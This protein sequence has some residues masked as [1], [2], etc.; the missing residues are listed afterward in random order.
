MGWLR[1]DEIKV[2]CES[3][4]ILFS[5]QKNTC[6]KAYTNLLMPGGQLEELSFCDLR[7]YIC[8]VLY[9]FDVIVLHFI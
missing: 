5:T 9:I 4:R 2:Y 3:H 1:Q 7:P 6:W 8:H